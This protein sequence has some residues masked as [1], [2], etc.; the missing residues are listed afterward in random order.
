[1]KKITHGT[2]PPLVV[3]SICFQIFYKIPNFSL[4]LLEK[5]SSPPS[6]FRYLNA[7]KYSKYQKIPNAKNYSNIK[8]ND[9]K[10]NTKI[11]ISLIPLELKLCDIEFLCNCKVPFYTEPTIIVVFL[12][13][14]SSTY[15]SNIYALLLLVS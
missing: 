4:N 12:S 2:S 14:I 13:F 10:R 5:N 9:F 6:I 15:G 8:H 1:M 3:S 7:I 11:G